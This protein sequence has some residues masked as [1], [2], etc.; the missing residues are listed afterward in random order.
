MSSG[1]TETQQMEKSK[2]LVEQARRYSPGG[3]HSHIRRELPFPM[4]FKRAQGAYLWDADGNR[5]IDYNAAFAA[6]ILGHCHPTVDRKVCEA[7][8][9]LDLVGLGTTEPEIEL[10][11]KVVEHVPSAEMAAICNTGSE[12]T[13]HCIRLA[14][15]VTGRM[16]IV[17]F[18]GCYH[19]WH[20]YVLM[21]VLSKPEKLGTK[22][23]HS[24][25]MMPAAIEHTTVLEF[26]DL[27]G[28]EK[29]LRTEEYATVI[30]EPIGHNMG[31]VMMTDEFAHGLRRICDETGTILIFDEV[32]TGVRHGL[33]G[34]QATIGIMPDLTPLS[35]AIGNGYPIAVM[36]GK[37]DLMMN[38]TTAGGTVY[39][40][41]TH[42]AHPVGTVA[43][44]ATIRE[45]EDGK[46]Y[47][48]LFGLGD[49][50]REGLQEIVTRRGLPIYVAGYGSI[51][52]PYFR[53]PEL[54]PPMNYT[55]VVQ[56]DLERDREFRLEMV[57]RGFM[58]YPLPGRRNCLMAAHAK[59]D[60]D[61]TLEA[62]DDVLGT[63][64]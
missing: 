48:H 38:L 47:E 55:D 20:D 18:Q 22:D 35:K 15:A 4:A 51:F 33:G 8:S 34:Y 53:D 11:R 26:N 43:A 10:S 14:R 44:V 5:Y 52:V 40:S 56:C 28:V 30:V 2:A 25:G 12:A 42:N 41:G 63:L 58:L 62:A 1:A 3:L 64:W 13:H 59:E 57:K 31:S 6:T 61:L 16:K 9:Q 23:P 50:V 17:K 39:F 45:L 7:V 36:A 60:I 29:T 32:I 21:N 24:G 49:Y 37:R 19:G 46:V 27:E 54:G